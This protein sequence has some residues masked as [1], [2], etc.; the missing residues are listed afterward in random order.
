MIYRVTVKTTSSVQPGKSGTFWNRETTY[1]GTSLEDAR[2]EYLRS[3]N[4]D[5]GGSF[6]NRCRETIIEA[7]D[8][9]PDEIDSTESEAVDVA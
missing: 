5:Y 7:F 9:E 1:C 6:G 8:S 4:E 2:V 3:L